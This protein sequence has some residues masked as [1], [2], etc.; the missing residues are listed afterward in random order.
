MRITAIGVAGGEELPTSSDVGASPSGD[1]DHGSLAWTYLTSFHREVGRALGQDLA[2][3][4]HEHQ[5]P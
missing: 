1:R 4:E 5:R 2:A 3:L